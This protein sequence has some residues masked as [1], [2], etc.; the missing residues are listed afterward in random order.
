MFLQT[1]I[2]MG[3]WIKVK[4]LKAYFH[5]ANKKTKDCSYSFYTFI[6]SICICTS[7]A[8][9]HPITIRKSHSFGISPLLPLLW[10]HVAGI[11]PAMKE[12]NNDGYSISGIT[13]KG[14][15]HNNFELEYHPWD[16]KLY[17]VFIL[18]IIFYLIFLIPW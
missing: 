8:S 6:V 9:S 14:V 15:T 10:C 5:S 7:I 4:G 12:V 3:N 18:L 1:T 13:M 2:K 11:K 16:I 17:I